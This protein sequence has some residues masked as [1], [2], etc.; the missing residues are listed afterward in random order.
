[1]IVNFKS[2]GIEDLQQEKIQNEQ[3]YMADALAQFEAK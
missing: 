1:M 3:Q 2:I